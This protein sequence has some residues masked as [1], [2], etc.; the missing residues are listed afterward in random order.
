MATAVPSI[1]FL[2]LVSSKLGPAIEAQKQALSEASKYSIAAVTG[3]DLVKVYNAARHEHLQY[4]DALQ[5]ATRHY[6]LQVVC[7][8]LQM[9]YIKLWMISLFIIGFYFAVVLVNQGNL[10]AGSALTTFYA[11]MTAFQSIEALGPQWLILVKGMAAGQ[12]LQSIMSEAEDGKRTIKIGG[13][14]RPAGCAGD[15]QLTN[16]SF[17]YPTATGKL[18]LERSS[19]KFPA[20]NM[21]FLVGTSGSGKSTIASLLLRFYEPLTGT[22]SLDSHPIDCLDL[23]WLRRNITLVQ[24]SSV[25]FQGTFLHNVALGAYNP[26]QVSKQDVHEACTMA[27][28][29][30]TITSLPQGLDTHLGSAGQSLSGGQK[31]RLAIARARLRDPP[32][33]ILDEVTSGLDPVSRA[34]IME[35]IRFWRKGKTTIVITHEV[36]QIDA[37]DFVYVLHDGRIV[38]EGYKEDLDKSDGGLLAHFLS[39][40]VADENEELS[41]PSSQKSEISEQ[42]LLSEEPTS[43]IDRVSKLIFGTRGSYRQSGPGGLLSRRTLGSS[44]IQASRIRTEQIWDAGTTKEAT[45]NG[46]SQAYASKKPNLGI[47]R[48]SIRETKRATINMVEL[49]GLSAKEVRSPVSRKQWRQS[50]SGSGDEA[51]ESLENFFLHRAA[52]DRKKPKQGEPKI[53]SLAVVLGTVWPRLDA[54]ARICSILG[55]LMCLI[56]AGSNPAFSFLFAN[57]LESFWLPDNRISAG[58]R[59]AAALGGIAVIDASSTF[60]SFFLMEKAAQKWVDNLRSEAFKRILDQPKP[61][62]DE[63]VHTPGGIAECLDRNAEEARKLVGMFVPIILTV[64]LMISTSLVWALAIRWDLTLVALAGLPFA[65][66]TAR[67]N[68]IVSDKWQ[69]VC[70]AAAD[71]SSAIFAETF[72]NIRVIR[73]FTLEESSKTKHSTS[74]N[75]AFR[76]GLQRAFRAGIFYGLYQSIAFFLTSLVFFYA[77]KIMKDGRVSVTDVLRVVNLLMF[78]LG[79]STSMIGNIPQIAAAKITAIQMLH[80]ANLVPSS[81]YE[82]GG[83]ERVTRPVPVRMNTLGF[84]YPT[85]A[86]TQVLRNVNLQ[87]DEDTCTA[88]VGPS[89]CGKSTIAALLLR[90]YEPPSGG[91]SSPLEDSGRDNSLAVITRRALR[92]SSEHPLSYS[93]VPADEINTASLR[94]H[95]AYVPQHPFLFPATIRENIIYGIHEQSGGRSL[96]DIKAA[97]RAAGIHD[98]VASLPDGYDTL[99]GEG[100]LQMSGGQAQRV[101]IARALARRPKLLVM[102]E[103][104]SALDAESAMA[105]RGVI[106][107]LVASVDNSMAVVVITHSKEMMRIADRIVVVQG[108]TVAETGEYDE[109]VARRGRFAQLVGAGQWLGEDAS[110]SREGNGQGVR[111]KSRRRETRQQSHWGGRTGGLS[112]ATKDQER[113][114]PTTTRRHLPSSQRPQRPSSPGL[115]GSI[116]CNEDALRKLQGTDTYDSSS[117]S[118]Q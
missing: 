35:A 61:W 65:I 89:G 100:G 86:G 96:S 24:Q 6:S 115:Q 19:L 39:A 109:L 18:A 13:S 118:E 97:A 85:R 4:V 116:S 94:T 21:V 72:S 58:S 110:A 83:T 80:Y 105:V 25:L 11:V 45:N 111:Q 98:F 34:L 63:D 70:D 112:L 95:M 56:V 27:L 53:P 66:G 57:L 17:G 78:S 9:G 22:I 107:D 51:M 44:T 30:S 23:Q 12:A 114:D 1:A 103:P 64:I 41:R 52:K 47:S 117:G 33:L 84:G 102:D 67:A 43:R 5:K 7:N 32:V 8:C 60:L 106:S 15:I 88:I 20:G 14:Y 49:H 29:Q 93:H 90:L 87:I 55:L 79:T 73:A 75:L 40:A 68:S 26:N 38:Q 48:G 42:N 69:T 71:K 36:S 76:Y 81:N 2:S 82:V 31:Q 113:L 99:V 50:S 92:H 28:L 91:P 54:R 77:S 74:A 46:S 104:T 10:S 37:K 3:I 101:S 108:G 59:W 16:V 62:F